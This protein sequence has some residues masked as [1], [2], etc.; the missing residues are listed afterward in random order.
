MR[1]A[2]GIGISFQTVRRW[3]NMLE[4]RSK[5]PA[6]SFNDTGPYRIEVGLANQLQQMSITCEQSSH[7]G[8][9][10]GGNIWKLTSCMPNPD[11]PLC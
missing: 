1:V 5:Y 3:R 11:T 10:R 6:Q 4:S 7:D 2:V 8:G 9:K